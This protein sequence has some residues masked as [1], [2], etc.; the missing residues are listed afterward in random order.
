MKT[1]TCL[2]I[3]GMLAMFSCDPVRRID[4]KNQSSDTAHV[5]WTL[6]ED[7]LMNNPFLISN[8]KELKFALYSPKRE[9]I[10]MSFGPGN[11]SPKEVQKLVGHL[12]SLEIISA[13]QRIK[14]DSLPLLKDFLLARRRGVGGA[15][16][17]IVIP[18]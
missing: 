13:T 15:R 6:N 18:K 7:S 5:I 2:F 8:S 12:T 11:W 10:K 16:I 9:E 14:I 17:E 3:L 4:V 1:F